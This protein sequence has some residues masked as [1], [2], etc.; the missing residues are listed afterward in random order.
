MKSEL[1]DDKKKLNEQF[2][3]IEKVINQN[4]KKE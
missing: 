3:L 1:N 4:R 2:L